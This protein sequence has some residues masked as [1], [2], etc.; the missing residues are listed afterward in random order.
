MWKHKHKLRK[1]KST[2]NY[3]PSGLRTNRIKKEVI[4]PSYTPQSLNQGVYEIR[5]L[6]NNK[7]YI[8]STTNFVRRCTQHF[9][10]LQEGTH[11]NYFLQHDYNLYGKE[12]FEFRRLAVTG[13][14]WSR[15]KLYRVEQS[16]LN[17]TPNK[18][19]I[20]KDAK[21]HLKHNK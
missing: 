6:K 11:S 5:C 12:H 16:Y 14:D 9:N 3:K 1:N 21:A 20:L 2:S 18:Y 17:C 15:N 13:Q 4:G 10:R 7:V 8:G 19:N